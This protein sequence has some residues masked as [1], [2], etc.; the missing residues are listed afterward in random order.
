MDLITR[1]QNILKELQ[2]LT[3]AQATGI[4]IEIAENLKHLSIVQAEPIKSI[5][6]KKDIDPGMN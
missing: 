5:E 3:Q 1:R 2:G 6:P 4:L